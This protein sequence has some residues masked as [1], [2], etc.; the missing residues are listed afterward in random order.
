M[1][2]I[3]WSLLCALIA[4]G[5][6]TYMLR[7]WSNKALLYIIPFVEEGLKTGLAVWASLV[8]WQV[9]LCF[10]LI[11]AAND[12]K[13]GGSW[14]SALYSV[15]SHA[16]FGAITVGFIQFLSLWL[17]IILVSCLHSLW[18]RLMLRQ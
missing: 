5:I 11:E 3:A 12:L 2:L 13:S 17:T 1:K 9:H 16:V 8:I 7:I 14:S 18:N 15:L 4:Y 6:N 10:G